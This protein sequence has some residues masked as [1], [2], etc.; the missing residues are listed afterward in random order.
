MGGGVGGNSEGERES[1]RGE[2]V[3]TMVWLSDPSVR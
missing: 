2:R 3:Y 1:E